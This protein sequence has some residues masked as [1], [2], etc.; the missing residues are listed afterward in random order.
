MKPHLLIIIFL[1]GYRF[2]FSQ[3]SN[4]IFDNQIKL[5][6]GVYTTLSEIIENNPKYHDCLFE[7]K[8]DFWFGKMSIYYTDKFGAKHEF[9][10]TILLVVEDGKRYVKY[11][12]GFYKLILTGAISTF[13]IETSVYSAGYE[14]KQAK[15]YF[16]DVK[17]GKTDKLNHT[18]IDE[19]IRRD[20]T[21]YSSYSA[22][23]DSK[24]AKTLYSYVLKYNLR[25][26]IY[27]K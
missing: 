17:T 2:L 6:E 27:I 13:F 25:N 4:S 16:W 18:N 14:D 11:K 3:E 1:F 20:S 5:K 10:D 7:T 23:S 8:V 21:V 24:K 9:K 12:N 15:L 19:I 22:I 26:P